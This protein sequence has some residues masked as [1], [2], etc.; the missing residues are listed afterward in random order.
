[1]IEKKPRI[2]MKMS[3]L[4]LLLF[5]WMTLGQADQFYEQD[6]VALNG[7]D[8]VAYFTQPQ[9]VKGSPRFSADYLG[10]TFY[11]S[12]KANWDSFTAH[13]ERFIPQYAGNCAFG[14]AKG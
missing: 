5:G 2:V 9:P 3:Y 7:Y 8:P 10:S 4:I 13:P 11:F 6:N 1:M 12:T 14:V